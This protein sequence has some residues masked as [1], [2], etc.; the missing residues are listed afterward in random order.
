MIICESA[1]GGGFCKQ[2]QTGMGKIHVITIG[3]SSVN[4]KES[5]SI[6]FQGSVVNI[7]RDMDEGN[8]AV[9]NCQ[10]MQVQKVMHDGVEIVWENHTTE[11]RGAV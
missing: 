4:V 8:G 3:S 7:W 10:I 5:E 1:D 6:D 11:D 9:H 2:V